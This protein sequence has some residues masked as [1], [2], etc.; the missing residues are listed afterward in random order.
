MATVKNRKQM[1]SYIM[2]TAKYDFSI[3]E[4]R[5]IYHLVG[6]AQHVLK[7]KNMADS[8][9]KIQH[10]LWGLVNIEMPISV[11]LMSEK[12][13][14]HKR[15]KQALHSLSEKF[16][17]YEDAE[18]WQKINI[19]VFPN[20]NKR[21][22]NISFVIHPK[23]WD[24][25]L[26]F[27]KGY[28]VYE[29]EKAMS[30]KSVYAM[31]F[32]ELFSEKTEPIIYTVENLKSMLG[33]SG[34]YKSV[35]DFRLHVLLVAQKELNKKSPYS[36]TFE[37]IKTGKKITSFRFTPVHQPQFEDKKLKQK[38]LQK[39]VNLSWD[40][41]REERRILKD[42]FNFSSAE[43]KHNIKVFLTAKKELNFLQKLDD[44]HEY[45]LKNKTEIKNVKGYVVSAL[46]KEI[47]N[48]RQGKLFELPPPPADE[49][50]SRLNELSKNLANKLKI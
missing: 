47:E 9:V 40:F 17:I 43:I 45:I 13:K 8:C 50:E 15:V 46:R 39:S 24:C 18:S 44:I 33:V 32:Y 19:V 20:V 23:I 28:R 3:Y 41:D 11:L 36:F 2:T 30:F 22:S 26:D 16:F 4:K 29:L 25:I 38:N 37:P 49:Q 14:N 27:S 12:D 31:R 5:I 10:E 42:Y 6:M 34:K 7:G 1:Q 35:K 21:G 48:K